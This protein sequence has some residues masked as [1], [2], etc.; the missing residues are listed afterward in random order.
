MY[1]QLYF[2]RQY[3]LDS[4]SF[5]Y[6]RLRRAR[7]GQGGIKTSGSSTTV[8]AITAGI[9]TFASVTVG[10]I[11]L[12]YD[13]ETKYERKVASVV[14]PDQITVD[15]ALNIDNSGA[16][17]PSW[18]V[19]PFEIGTADTDGWQSC[20]HLVQESKK[21]RI[22]APAIQAAG[23][24]DIQIETLDPGFSSR[25]SVVLGPVNFPASAAV[26]KEYSV[27]ELCRAIRLG[28]KGAS[29]FAGTDSITAW[30]IGEPRY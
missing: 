9:G 2:Y 21:V 19:M 4:T 27:P 11:L 10:D 22:E 5:K 15:S 12:I 28:V 6:G 18:Y 23:G 24:L 16:G 26:A 14:S 13:R 25:P 1:D 8:D 17:V 30:L 3:D 29:G 20:E 7:P